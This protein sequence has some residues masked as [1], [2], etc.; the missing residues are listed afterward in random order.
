MSKFVP[1]FSKFGRYAKFV[2][3]LV[4]QNEVRTCTQFYGSVGVPFVPDFAEA[5]QVARARSVKQHTVVA[6]NIEYTSTPHSSVVLPHAV[7]IWMDRQ[8]ADS[9]VFDPNGAVHPEDRFVVR[10]YGTLDELGQMYRIGVPQDPGP[11]RECPDTPG[12]IHGGG[13]C[14]FYNYWMI[15]SYFNQESPS[16]VDS[17]KNPDNWKAVP[18]NEEIGPQSLD[19]IRQVF[20]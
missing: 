19:T 3:K 14:D 5:H 9:F 10:K 1:E 2:R 8:N 15:Q 20:K 6:T 4:D 17:I 13:Y 7:T 12:F 16:I 11:Q 18:S